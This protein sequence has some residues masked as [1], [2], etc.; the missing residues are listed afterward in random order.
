M[1]NI[2]VYDY[3][4]NNMNQ[5][6]KVR[7]FKISLSRTFIFSFGDNDTIYYRKN[8]I[9]R[10]IV[11]VGKEKSFILKTGINVDDIEYDKYCIRD[12]SGILSE[13]ISYDY[14][15]DALEIVNFDVIEDNKNKIITSD[16]IIKRFYRDEIVTMCFDEDSLKLNSVLLVNNC[17]KY[18]SYNNNVSV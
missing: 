8:S 2:K 16:S 6:F 13:Y 17:R 1:R 18:N 11:L 9:S 3:F 14:F 10:K 15:P 12:I 5:S 4:F 7:F